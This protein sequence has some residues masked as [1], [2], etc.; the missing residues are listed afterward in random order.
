MHRL[1]QKVS[2]SCGQHFNQFH[3]LSGLLFVFEGKINGLNNQS[4]HMPYAL[5][6]T[7]WGTQ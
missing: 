2:D 1:W 3:Q 6:L 4:L 7:N 5:L